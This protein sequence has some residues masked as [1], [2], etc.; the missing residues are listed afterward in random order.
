[1]GSGELMNRKVIFI[2]H[3]ERDISVI[4]DEKAAPLTQK[5]IEQA[6]QLVH[7]IKTDFSSITAIY[8]SPFA[9][10]IQTVEPTAKELGIKITEISDLRERKVGDQWIDNFD[11]YAQKQWGNFDYKLK[12]GE[13]LH[14]VQ[15]RIVKVF[16]ELLNEPNK[17]IIISGHGTALA[18]L[19]HSFSHEFVY[20]DWLM[21]KFPDL[22]VAEIGEN[23]SVNKFYHYK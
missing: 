7:T 10:A 6:L 1:M 17:D 18:V 2:R 9:R 22:F 3:A 11:E 8:S 21:M 5:G 23:Q 19:F 16:E 20:Q 14:H 13:N 4:D 15:K 12:N